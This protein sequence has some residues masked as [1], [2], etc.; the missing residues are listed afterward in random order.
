MQMVKE[1]PEAATSVSDLLV[2]RLGNRSPVVKYKVGQHSQVSVYI[3]QCSM[4]T[5]S[6]QMVFGA[7]WK[8]ALPRRHIHAPALLIGHNGLAGDCPLSVSPN[9]SHS[10]NCSSK[11]PCTSLDLTL[12]PTSS[13]ACRSVGLLGISV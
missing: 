2:K 4:N 10:W 7:F 13:L 6:Y 12:R 8:S 9:K 1:S 5:Q 11:V 3:E